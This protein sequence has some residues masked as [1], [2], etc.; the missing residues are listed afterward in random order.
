MIKEEIIAEAKHWVGERDEESEY[1]GRVWMKTEAENVL[2]N[3]FFYIS[4]ISYL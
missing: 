4:L 1:T 3:S 2:L